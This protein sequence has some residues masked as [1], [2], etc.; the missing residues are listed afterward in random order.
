LRTFCDLDGRRREL[1]TSPGAHGSV[2][3]IDRDASTH[4]DRRLVAHLAADEPPANAVLVSSHYARDAASRRCRARPL[5][6]ED[7]TRPPLESALVPSATF[8]PEQRHLSPDAGDATYVLAL[9]R[10]SLSIPELRWRLVAAPTGSAPARGVIVTLRDVVAALE[11]Y[12]PATSITRDALFAYH[13]A[14]AVSTS[15]LRQE[16]ARLMR[17]PIVL[18]RGLREALLARLARGEVSMSEIAM[19]CGRIK[20]DG[21][22]NASGETSWLARRVGLLPEGGAAA[23]TPW[24]HT[25]VLALI[26]R[27]GLCLSPREVEL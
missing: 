24:I 9:E 12:E 7:A 20:R 23:P 26:A 18:N 10:R 1:I 17:S 5:L 4:G 11:S 15:A 21:R 14:S 27:Q 6:A 8:I 22:G 16:L 3:V 19:R 2:L 25:D 13:G